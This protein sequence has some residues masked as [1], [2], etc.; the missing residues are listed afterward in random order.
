MGSFPETHNVSHY[1]L[2]KASGYVNLCV[3][4]KENLYIRK[5]FTSLRNTNMGAVS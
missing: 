5:R 1:T 2:Y 3:R 4:A